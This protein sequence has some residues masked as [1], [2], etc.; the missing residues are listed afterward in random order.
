LDNA[1]FNH[2]DVVHLLVDSKADVKNSTQFVV[3]Y[4]HH[5][6]EVGKSQIG[7]ECKGAESRDKPEIGKPDS[8]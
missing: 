8:L 5:S 6:L 1:Q 3:I 7:G 2:P 4:S